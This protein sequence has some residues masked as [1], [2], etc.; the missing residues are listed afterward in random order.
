MFLAVDQGVNSF[1]A[2]TN[3]PFLLQRESEKKFAGVSLVC[4]GATLKQT[5]IFNSI[6]ILHLT[7]YLFGNLFEICYTFI[8]ISHFD[9]CIFSCGGVM[10]PV[11]HCKNRTRLLYVRVYIVL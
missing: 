11:L 10:P 5:H 9:L 7:F 4:G 2:A 3:I 1:T 8:E 6:F